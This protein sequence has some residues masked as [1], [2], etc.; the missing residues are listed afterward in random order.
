MNSIRYSNLR[1]RNLPIV[2][3]VVA[4]CFVACDKNGDFPIDPELS[5]NPM[6][7]HFV[8]EVSQQKIDIESNREWKIEDFPSWLTAV[9]KTG[10]GG[11][12]KITVIADYNPTDFRVDSF[13]V[14][15]SS[16]GKYVVV[17]QSGF[18]VVLSNPATEIF[19]SSAVLNGQWLYSGDEYT[20]AEIGYALRK[21]SDAYE[22]LYVQRLTGGSV[23]THPQAVVRPAATGNEIVSCRFSL[24]LSGLGLTSN[25]TFKPYVKD[26]EGN[27]Y[28]GPERTFATL[29]APEPI[30]IS[31]LRAAA[32]TGNNYIKGITLTD[33]TAGNYDPAKLVIADGTGASNAIVLNFANVADHKFNAGDSLKVR[34]FGAKMAKDAN[35]VLNLSVVAAGIDLINS[36]NPVTPV[37]ITPN[38]L[39]AYESVYVNIENTQLTDVTK[40]YPQWNNG[41]NPLF[42]GEVN[43]ETYSYNIHV[44]SGA[45]FAGTAPAQGSGSIKGVVTKITPY[46]Y[47]VLPR[48]TADVSLAGA[49]FASNLQFAWLTPRFEGNLYIEEA[50]SNCFIA[51]PY[52]NGDGSAF[53]GEVSARAAA[54]DW[55]VEG[56]NAIQVT[57]VDNPALT[58]NGAVKLAVTGTPYA[59]GNVTFEILGVPGLSNIT[60]PVTNPPAPEFG[61]FQAVWTANTYGA[62]IIAAGSYG[63]TAGPVQIPH[64]DLS[65]VTFNPSSSTPQVPLRGSTQSSVELSSLIPVNFDPTGASNWS[66]AWGGVG[67]TANMDVMEPERYAYF[68]VI[69]TAGVLDLSGLL[70]VVRFGGANGT[71]T[72]HFQYSINDG[73]FQQIGKPAVLAY[74]GTS[75]TQGYMPNTGTA[76][77]PVPV[78][79]S[80]VAALQ[81]LTAGT[82][83]TIRLVPVCAPGT[84][85]N[86]T[87]ALNGAWSTNPLSANIWGN[88]NLE[89]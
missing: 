82:K 24:A 38:N 5:V 18:P 56:P 32:S 46:D 81:E 89:D 39:S 80:T 55:A 23:Q 7:L 16:V 3:A 28:Y 49:R 51:L 36:G 4:M 62:G 50:A 70:F 83:V 9:Q 10:A 61:N 57:S 43:G 2:F 53:S 40:A 45:G 47:A 1:L 20:I 19:E 71:V 68:T 63:N 14:R 86:F 78:N 17:Y 69:P 87:F 79:L 85:A 21:E 75:S 84:A 8:N 88:L 22:M 15:V 42:A 66:N 72:V 58:A 26:S 74:S 52:A 31:A 37:T 13:L 41:S 65:G 11:S 73:D 60:V 33:R 44:L 29:A 6:V 27:V 25:Y 59:L 30:A 54:P 48:N 64:G 76:S 35:G 12:N 77:Q 67:W 34:V